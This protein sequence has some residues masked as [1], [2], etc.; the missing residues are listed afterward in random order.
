VTGLE[1]A[2]LRGASP[3]EVV[4]SIAVIAVIDEPG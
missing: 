4:I 3:P 2:Q 1:A